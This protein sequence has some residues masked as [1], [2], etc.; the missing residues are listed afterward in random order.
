M[1]VVESVKAAAEDTI[2]LKK[3]EEKKHAFKDATLAEWSEQQRKLRMDILSCMNAEKIREMKTISG[4]AY[5][6]LSVGE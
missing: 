6:S 4:T 1:E 3:R 5:S 2:G